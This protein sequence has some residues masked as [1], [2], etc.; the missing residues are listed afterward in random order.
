MKVVLDDVV[1]EVI[2][3]KVV[4]TCSNEYCIEHSVKNKLSNKVCDGGY[5]GSS[6][7][8]GS[9]IESIEKQ[10]SQYY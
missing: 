8:L 7:P 6:S 4:I 1:V 10:T 2:G 9:Q 5:S 3:K